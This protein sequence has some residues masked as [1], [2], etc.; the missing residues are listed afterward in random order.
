[1]T[2]QEKLNFIITRIVTIIPEKELNPMFIQMETVA[3]KFV[4]KVETG[5]AKSKETYSDMKHILIDLQ[6]L[7]DY[8]HTIRLADILLA[9]NTKIKFYTKIPTIHIN[10]V[11]ALSYYDLKHDDITKQSDEFIDFIYNL[12]Q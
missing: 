10:I 5:K 4:N 9:L 12:L 7:E 3:R 2:Y 11:K 1:M 6:N 8:N